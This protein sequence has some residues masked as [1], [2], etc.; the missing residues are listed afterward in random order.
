MIYSSLGKSPT[1]I[2][3]N[4]RGLNI[5]QKSTQLLRHLRRENPAFVFFQETHFKANFIPKLTD[6]YFTKAYHAANT[7]SKT[8]GVPILIGKSSGFEL[9]QQLA[10]PGGRFLLLKGTIGKHALSR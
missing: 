8:K 1:V 10:D 7:E 4:V 2:S 3:H 9:T 5:P 6:N